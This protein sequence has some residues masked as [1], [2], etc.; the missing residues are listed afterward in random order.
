MEFT[1][2][3]YRKNVELLRK[4][5]ENVPLEEL[6]TK[7]AKGYEKLRCKIK[8]QT[9]ECVI[10]IISAGMLIF[11]DDQ[12]EIREVK[13]RIQEIID[14]KSE[15]RREIGRLVFTSYDIDRAMNLA[16]DKIAT[17][18]FEQAYAPY[19]RSKCHQ[20]GD[21]F[22]CDLLPGMTW[23]KEYRVWIGKD[24]SFTVMLAPISDERED[25]NGN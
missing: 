22:I 16:A 19:F 11:K 1:M 2:Q 21:T 8:Q 9:E 23:N 20:E 25:K 12:D 14:Q 4:N 13:R 3:E 5:K 7:Y 24:N 15:I 17:P 18:C 10:S 6:K